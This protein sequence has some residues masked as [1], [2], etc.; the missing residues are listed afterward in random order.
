MEENF[1]AV[2]PKAAP[3]KELSPRERAAAR[4]KEVRDNNSGNLDDGNDEFAIDLDIIPD[5]WSYE[6]KAHSVM[7][8]VDPSHQ[9]QLRK[10]GWE[11]V[12]ASRHP[13]LMPTG[14]TGDTI[15]RKGMILMERP[16]E[17]TKEARDIANRNARLQVR[18]KEEQLSAAPP[19]QFERNNK[20]NTL[21]K[22][23]KGYE[24]IEIPE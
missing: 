2:K 22:V 19:G 20:D 7:G 14:Y 15:L 17:L 8:A 5:D 10:K 6:W 4:A 9:I 21:V 16:M 24:K 23:K 1:T 13:E 3:G 12:P 11:P 18:A